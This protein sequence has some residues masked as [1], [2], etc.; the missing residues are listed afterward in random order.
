MKKFW[1][2]L[3]ALALTI[4]LCACGGKTEAEPTPEPETT[5]T[6][7]TEP[8]PT[9]ASTEL[10]SG[11]FETFEAAFVGAE[12]FTDANG[13]DAL[14]VYFDF[15]NLSA[16]TISAQDRLLISAVQDGKALVWAENEQ[17]AVESDNLT[18]RVQSGHPI[19]CVLEYALVSNSPVAILLDDDEGHT[20]SALLPLDKLPGAPASSSTEPETT[21][22]SL[23]TQLDA[24]CELFG[25][26]D[27]AILGGEVTDTDTGRVM[28]VSL[29]FTNH[30]DPQ[31]VD[32]WSCFRL[33]AYQDG[34]ELTYAA[35]EETEIETAAFGETLNTSI[36]FSLRSESP[37]LVELYSFREDVPSAGL[38]IP[39]A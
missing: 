38:V 15:T 36:A 16:E 6:K 19:R 27:V 39:V 24:S 29:D 33:F 25:L 14:R 2:L 20:V 13:G 1:T 30:S 11:R 23:T 18:L 3:L 21:E 28:T 12:I 37:V 4:A 8:T 7:T 22:E 32:V 26:Y 17:T 10:G 5:E 9:P 35:M 31:E 34:V